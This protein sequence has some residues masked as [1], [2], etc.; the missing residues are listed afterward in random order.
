MK[1][2]I[3]NKFREKDMYSAYI[4]HISKKKEEEQIPLDDILDDIIELCNKEE[5]TNEDIKTIKEKSTKCDFFKKFMETI[6]KIN[7][8]DICE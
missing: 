1:S 6:I 2:C 5:L 7:E 8:T 3:K 4:N